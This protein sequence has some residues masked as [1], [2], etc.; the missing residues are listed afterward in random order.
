MAA[1]LGLQIYGWVNRFARK[2]AAKPSAEG[3]MTI[4]NKD[5]IRDLSNEILTKFMKHDVPRS[6][7]KSEN[8]IKVIY[9]QIKNMEE[10]TLA[11]NLKTA[12]TPKK[13]ADVLD[14]TGKKI[15]TSKPILGGKNVPESIDLSKY[16]DA[17]LNAL[18]DEDTKLLAEAN[19]LSEAGE[20]YGRVKAI[21]ARREEIAKILKAA[22]DVPESGYDNFR[23]DLAAKKQTESQIKTK[24]E[25]PGQG[26]FTKAEYLIQRLKNTIKDNPDDKYVQETFPNFIKELEADPKL[27]KDE[28]VFREL[29]GDLPKDQQ[30]VVYDDDT[31]DFFTQKEGPGNIALLEKFMKDNPFLSREEGLNLLKMEPTDRV[32]ELTKLRHLNKKK[33]DNA[34]GG[35]IDY[36]LGGQ[37]I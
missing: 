30:I 23:A 5:A 2:L 32:L 25:K 13:S 24:L 12:L 14:I 7:L 22:Q 4:S 6:A 27:A 8:D 29:G 10:Q 21:K 17:A 28:H 33:T 36:A 34:E 11:K 19:K 9:N 35:I 15:D 1:K 26:K 16:D 20:N 3:I 31:L 37:I 18:V